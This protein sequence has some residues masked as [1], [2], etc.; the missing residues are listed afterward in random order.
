[1]KSIDILE[2]LIIGFYSE[3]AYNILVNKDKKLPIFEF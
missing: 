3:T 2:L 1:M